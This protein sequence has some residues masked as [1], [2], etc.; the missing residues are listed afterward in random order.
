MV[1]ERNL[2]WS[3]QKLD[4]VTNAWMLGGGGKGW[5][6]WCLRSP[7]LR[8]L[9]AGLPERRGGSRWRRAVYR[10]GYPTSRSPWIHGWEEKINIYMCIWVW[11]VYIELVV[12]ESIRGYS[13]TRAAQLIQRGEIRIG[14]LYGSESCAFKK[15]LKYIYGRHTWKFLRK[16]ETLK[17]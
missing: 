14:E 3:G 12:A 16:L 4:F 17:D 6:C 10:R 5:R 15:V 1:W 2:S 13:S 8:I 9:V 11:V 7:Q